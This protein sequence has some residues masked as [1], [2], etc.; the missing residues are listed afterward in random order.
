LISKETKA[1]LH[2]LKIYLRGLDPTRQYHLRFIRSAKA[3][4]APEVAGGG[5]WINHGI[6][7]LLRGDFQAAGV[8]LEAT[9]AH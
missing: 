6:N 7:V 1:L 9:A 3:L 2:F 5:Y 8:V 4:D